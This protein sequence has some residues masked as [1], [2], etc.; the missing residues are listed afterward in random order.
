[1]ITEKITLKSDIEIIITDAKTKEIKE[2]KHFHNLITDNGFK[3]LRNQLA[4]VLYSEDQDFNIETR[5][6]H[7]AIGN[8]NT[9]VSSTQTQLGN[10]IIRKELHPN[11]DVKCETILEDNNKVIYSIFLSDAEGNGEIIREIG[12]FAESD[13]NFMVSRALIGNLSKTSSVEFTIKYKIII[14]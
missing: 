8:S 11:P 13:T 10:E 14:E 7:I 12:L 9:P 4:N 6:T 1:M 2:I 5:L 3:W